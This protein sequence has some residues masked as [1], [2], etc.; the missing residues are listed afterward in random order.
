MAD[1]KSD[2]EIYLDKYCALRGVPRE[3]AEKHLIVQKVKKMYEEREKEHE[4]NLCG[5]S[6]A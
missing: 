2:Y 4:E 1:Q 5:G 3:E 6:N